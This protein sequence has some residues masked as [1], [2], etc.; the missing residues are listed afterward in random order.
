MLNTKKNKTKVPGVA[1]TLMG[2][3]A[4]GVGAAMAVMKAVSSYRRAKMAQMR[5]ALTPRLSKQD[6][7]AIARMEGEGGPSMPMP[8]PTTP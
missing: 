6:R 3:A 4:V 2:V 7:E 1:S 8:R 5:A